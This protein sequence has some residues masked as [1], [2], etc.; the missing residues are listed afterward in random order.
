MVI[1][2]IGVSGSGKT[3]IGKA[4]SVLTGSTFLDA[5]DY[6]SPANIAKM[7][8]GEALNEADRQPWL[9]ILSELIDSQIEL[10]KPTIL[11]CSALKKSYRGQLNRANPASVHFVYLK[12]T[13][14]LL[15]RRLRQR[16]GH[17]MSPELLLSQLETLEEPTP[18]EA[19]IVRVHTETSPELIALYI[20][21]K[22]ESQLL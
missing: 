1:I 8:R 4:L 18:T 20:Y 22:L 6:H 9:N 16:Q 19:T 13:P 12:L 3:S 11:A 14:E 10:D 21:N 15:E 5:D 7:S 17:F 2:L